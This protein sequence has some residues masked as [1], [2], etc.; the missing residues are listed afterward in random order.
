MRVHA[1]RMW[2]PAEARRGHQIHWGGS[3]KNPLTWMMGTELGSSGGES[4]ISPLSLAL[5]LPASLFRR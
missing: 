4:N 3:Y 5:Q 2:T 1:T